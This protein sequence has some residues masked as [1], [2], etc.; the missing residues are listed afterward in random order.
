MNRYSFDKERVKRLRSGTD[1]LN[2]SYNV[3]TKGQNVFIEGR[4]VVTPEQIHTTFNENLKRGMPHSI[5]QAFLFLQKKY[6]GVS[7]RKLAQYVKSRSDYQEQKRRPATYNRN[8]KASREGT[9]SW[10]FKKHPNSLGVDLFDARSHS[11]FAFLVVFMHLRTGFI[12]VFPMTSKK[13]SLVLS[14]LKLALPEAEKLGKITLMI[15]D[16]GSEFKSSFDN[17]LKRRGIQ[18]KVVRLV[19]QVE[20][21]N[22]IL[23]RYLR[24]NLKSMGF[25]KALP[26]TVKQINNIRS[27]ITGHT[28][29][30]LQSGTVKTF[31]RNYRTLKARPPATSNPILKKGDKVR[32]LL[33]RARRKG[34][35]FFKSYQKKIWS[36]PKV[37][38][39]RAKMPHQKRFKYQVGGKWFP[40][41]EIQHIKTITQVKGKPA[42]KRRRM[43]LR[44]GRQV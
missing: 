44:S 27:R 10:M 32:H 40:E 19:P 36:A 35:A 28:P 39:K 34:N 25:N 43:S 42:P 3:T 37:I 41:D 24:K 13:A 8:N 33:Q 26:L 6:V 4:Q 12:W 31:Q 38:Q 15:S 11:N 1:P 22:S 23:G 2:R 16:N 7:R 18:R 29:I 20:R 17:F 21:I 30:D 14:K 9:T 5:E